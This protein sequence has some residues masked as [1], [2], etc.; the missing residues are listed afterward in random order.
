MRLVMSEQSDAHQ[1][2][3][4]SYFSQGRSVMNIILCLI[5]IFLHYSHSCRF[6]RGPTAGSFTQLPLQLLSCFK[7]KLFLLSKEMLFR[8]N[9]HIYFHMMVLVFKLFKQLLQGIQTEHMQR[10][11]L[12]EIRGSVVVVTNN[13]P[14]LLLSLGNCPSY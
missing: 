1:I 13:N 5:S 7:R 6:N 11:P 8:C 4:I 3:L 10:G 2:L 12:V 14:F 9:L